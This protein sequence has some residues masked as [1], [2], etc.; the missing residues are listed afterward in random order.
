MNVGNG[1]QLFNI[2]NENQLTSILSHY[3]TEF[4][5][6]IVDNALTSRF[7]T[8]AILSSPN[9]VAAW[10]QNFKQLLVDFE[11]SADS[12]TSIMQVREDTYKEIIT[13][14][15]KEFH[16]NFTIDDDV[17]WYS[18]AYYLYDFFVSNFNV[19]LIN[20][21]ANYIYKERIGIYE[22]M[23]LATFRK[24][25]DSSTIYGKKIYKDIKLA[26]INANIDYVVTNLCGID[27][28]LA[29]IMNTIYAQK[30]LVAYLCTLIS[31]QDDFF[32]N[33]YAY[34]MNTPI[35]PILLT[36][37][38]FG[39]QALASAHNNIITDENDIDTNEEE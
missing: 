36:E 1:N 24:N 15:C 12:K 11:D 35:K 33:F 6:T 32:K 7:N 4:V 31:E 13:R 23:N 14:I 10:E 16:L 8:N 21:F 30:E 22:N 2:I 27:I 29:D 20:F 25:K 37:I 19:N 34:M 5:L 39:I 28:S 26:T 38:R 9:V 17:D 3:N 18:A